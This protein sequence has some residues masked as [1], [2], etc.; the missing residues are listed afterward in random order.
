MSFL[1]SLQVKGAIVGLSTAPRGVRVGP[2]D[3]VLVVIAG[4]GCGRSQAKCTWWWTSS[5]PAHALLL[6]H[7]CEQHRSSRPCLSQAGG[8]ASRQPAVWC[9]HSGHEVQVR[10]VEAVVGD[11]VQLGVGRQG[12]CGGSHRVREAGCTQHAVARHVKPCGQRGAGRGGLGAPPSQG[13][14]DPGS[15]R[16]HASHNPATLDQ[17]CAAPCT[18]PAHS[19]GRRRC[20]RW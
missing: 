16:G 7:P 18:G 10:A 20:C 19:T 11:T 6:C 8:E 4:Y 15:A 3:A 13:P 12:L 1:S 17:S 2:G 14:L 9:L 5:L